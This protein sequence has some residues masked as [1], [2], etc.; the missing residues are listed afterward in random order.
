MMW[1]ELRSSE[2]INLAE[3]ET[4]GESNRHTDRAARH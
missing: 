3:S 1:C 2:G 4:L